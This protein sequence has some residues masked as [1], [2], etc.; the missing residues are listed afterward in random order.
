MDGSA[1]LFGTLTGCLTGGAIGWVVS[2]ARARSAAEP[3][4]REA[5]GQARA[6]AATADELR[7]ANGLL[8]DRGDRLEADL[9]RADGER[10]AG[11]ARI[12]ELS[13]SLVEQKELLEAAKT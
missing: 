6:A 5:E 4:L 7:R 12:D 3:A 1:L 11:A 13:R 9:R 2:A 8:R 10:S